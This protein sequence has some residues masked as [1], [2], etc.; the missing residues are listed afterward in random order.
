[1]AIAREQEMRAEVE[2]MRARVVEA[3]SEVPRA[4]AEALKSGNLSVGGYYE[5][6][7]LKSD[8]AMREAIAGGDKKKIDEAGE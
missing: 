1:M 3:Q 7:N 5:L 6:E 8:T 2:A 4:L